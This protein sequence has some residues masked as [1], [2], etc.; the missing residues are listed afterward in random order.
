MG[1]LTPA[2]VTIVICSHGDERYRELALDR[3]RPS[4]RRQGA[5]EVIVL[6]DYRPCS[7]VAKVR[8]WALDM[9]TTSHVVHLD[10]D[11]ELEDG[12]LDALCAGTADL[13]APSVRYVRHGVVGSRVH[14]IVPHVVGH[15][16]RC[17]G[18]CLPFGNW[19]VVGALAPVELLQ[20]VGGWREWSAYEDWDLW[21]RCYQAGA[22]VEALPDAVYRAH[23][24]QDSRNRSGTRLDRLNTHRAIAADLGVPIP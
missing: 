23:V 10:A 17:V 9:V 4:A 8:N 19:I 20:R 3:A 7:T 13:R 22:T 14:P 21:L 24:R 2:D 11:D 18:D 15:D 12:Y 1:T 6:H 5:G 16:H